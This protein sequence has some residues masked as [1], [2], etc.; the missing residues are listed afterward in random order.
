MMHMDEG[1]SIAAEGHYCCGV[2]LASRGPLDCIL[3]LNTMPIV[4]IGNLRNYRQFLTVLCTFMY[5]PNGSNFYRFHKS[6]MKI[7]A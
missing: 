7:L 2:G 5:R 4:L 6:I 3:T 1:R